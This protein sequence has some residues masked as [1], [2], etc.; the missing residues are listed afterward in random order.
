MPSQGIN[1]SLILAK[2]VEVI[3]AIEKGVKRTCDIG[4]DMEICQ[5]LVN[6]FKGIRGKLWRVATCKMEETR[7]CI[8]SGD[9][10][11]F[12]ECF[13]KWLKQFDD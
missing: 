10:S 1:S 13:L 9:Y 5:T 2:K 6:I 7:K 4:K 12:D 3:N 8:R 11:Q